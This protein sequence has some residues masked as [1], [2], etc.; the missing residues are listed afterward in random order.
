MPSIAI[1]QP[2]YLPYIGYFQLMAEVDTFVVLDDVQYIRRGWINKNRVLLKG[3][4]KHFSIPLQKAPRSTLI[5]HIRLAEEVTHTQR[6]F[7]EMLRHAY[8]QSPGWEQLLQLMEPLSH[9]RA[10][11][12]LLPL[13]LDSLDQLCDRLQIRPQLHLASNIDL[14][15][16]SGV[17][18]ILALCKALGADT[19][20]NLP[21]GQKLYQASAFQAEGIKLRLL[22]P[23]LPQYAQSDTQTFVPALSILDAL[24]NLGPQG[25]SRLLVRSTLRRTA[26]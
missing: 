20:I 11:E 14:P 10:G 19:Y 16:M 9:A 4:I 6:K 2:Y 25:F 26:V 12:A 21:G 22:E 15:P 3:E 8:A 1:M 5:K 23:C 7:I 24:A 18:R 17:E 13:L